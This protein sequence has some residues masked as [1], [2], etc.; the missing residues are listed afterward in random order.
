MIAYGAP[1]ASPRTSRGLSNNCGCRWLT[2]IWRC[3][4]AGYARHC[5]SLSQPEAPGRCDAG[6]RSLQPW[7][8][9]LRIMSGRRLNCCPI[10]FRLTSWIPYPI[11][12]VFTH[13]LRK[14]ITAVE[15]HYHKLQLADNQGPTY[16]DFSL[17]GNGQSR[18]KVPSLASPSQFQALL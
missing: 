10:P 15:G 9:A 3:H 18:A 8:L 16:K 7:R 13:R 1:R 6:N 11:W 17:H 4:I 2:T 5:R 12:S 14:L